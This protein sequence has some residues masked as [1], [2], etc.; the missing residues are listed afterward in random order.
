M[1]PA[2]RKRI[3]AI[4]TLSAALAGLGSAYVMP[5]V[6]P[7]VIGRDNPVLIDLRRKNSDLQGFTAQRET[8]TEGAS[9][10]IVARIGPR[11]GSSFGLT[12]M[13]GGRQAG[14]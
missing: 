14:S 3:W 6:H 10:S 2:K 4:I 8:D 11:T 5:L 13:S 1:K 9:R 7:A 12:R